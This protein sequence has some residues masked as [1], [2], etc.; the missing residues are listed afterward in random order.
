ME[1][2]LLKDST[3]SFGEQRNGV[4]D[5]CRD[6]LMHDMSSTGQHWSDMVLA[7]ITSWLMAARQHGAY[8]SVPA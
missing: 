4:D 5:H 2:R 3:H 1:F 7:L 6:F 8:S